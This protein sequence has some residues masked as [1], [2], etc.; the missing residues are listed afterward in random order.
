VMPAAAYLPVESASTP[1]TDVLVSP[2]GRAVLGAPATRRA[3]VAR[4][5]VIAGTLARRGAADRLSI[6]CG[7][8]GTVRCVGGPGDASEAME[9]SRHAMIVS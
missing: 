7:G 9:C 6:Q 1:R 2:Q 4:E 3:P 5:G 8:S